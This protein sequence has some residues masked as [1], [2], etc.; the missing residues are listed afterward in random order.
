MVV[1]YNLVLSYPTALVS[2]Q[3]LVLKKK[4]LF[5]GTDFFFFVKSPPHSKCPHLD[6]RVL[7]FLQ[8]SAMYFSFPGEL[9][10]H[11]W[12]HLAF[13]SA[14][15]HRTYCSLLLV[16]PIPMPVLCSWPQSLSWEGTFCLQASH[17][18]KHTKKDDHK[19]LD[20]W[21]QTTSCREI[22]SFL[23]NWFLSNHFITPRMNF[24]DAFLWSYI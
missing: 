8:A 5:H 12:S 1:F 19:I 4:T 23:N 10:G 16:M 13:L 11:L 20:P 21:P 24:T 14:P 7:P 18:T 3:P 9:K 22:I 15:F 2:L 6:G 17:R